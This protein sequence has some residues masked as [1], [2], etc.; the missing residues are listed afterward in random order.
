[1][2][3][4]NLKLRIGRVLSDGTSTGGICQTNNHKTHNSVNCGGGE[5]QIHRYTCCGGGVISR[6]IQRRSRPEL[7]QTGE[8]RGLEEG[9]SARWFVSVVW[10]MAA[11]VMFRSN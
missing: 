5:N 10:V 3:S 4:P 8:A 7:A 2:P 6:A 1:M 9:C 11:G